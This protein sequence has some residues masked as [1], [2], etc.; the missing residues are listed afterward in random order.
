MSSLTIKEFHN[1][2][3]NYYLMLEDKFMNTLSYVMLSD[4]NYCSFS[5]EYA[6]LI[7]AI[8]SELDCF[9]K[10]FCNYNLE[11][12]KN[13]TDYSKEILQQRWTDIGNQVVIAN[14]LRI[15]PF[16]GWN[17][18]SAKK[19][20]S[21]WEAFDEIKHNRVSN[22]EKGS[23]EN[24]LYILAALYMLEMKWLKITA[25]S[26]GEIDIPNQQSKLF[27][28]DNWPTRS[29]SLANAIGISQ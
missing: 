6:H 13:I 25:D 21:W 11:E 7:Q 15:Q 12:I 22:V 23:L 20:L 16:Y 4:K 19:T 26:C 9:F 5:D 18:N 3:W 8:G 14:E 2:Y 10:E 29:I 17:S 1:K 27:L 28:L 24:A